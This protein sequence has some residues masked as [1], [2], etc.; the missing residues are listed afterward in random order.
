V[1]HVSVGNQKNRNV[2]SQEKTQAIRRNAVSAEDRRKSK[3]RPGG[4]KPNGGPKKKVD[5]QR[6]GKRLE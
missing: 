2:I 4:R 3:R 6:R 5:K 1:I